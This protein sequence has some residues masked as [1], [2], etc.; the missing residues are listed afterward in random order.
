MIGSQI[1]TPG[2]TPARKPATLTTG[3][4]PSRTL[5]PA[6]AARLPQTGNQISQLAWALGSLGLFAVLSHCWL[7]RQ[8]RP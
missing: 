5:T 3:Q 4:Q 2:G 1:E 7:R 6:S 8:L